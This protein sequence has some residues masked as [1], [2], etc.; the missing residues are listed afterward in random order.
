MSYNGRESGSING[1]EPP[2]GQYVE[3]AD[4][5]IFKENGVIKA[6]NGEDGSIEFSGSDF[7]TVLQNAIDDLYGTPGYGKIY[8]RAGKYTVSSTITLKGSIRLV[9]AGKNRTNLTLAD[10][11]N[12]DLIHVCPDNFA[13][14]P[15]I[16]FMNISGN[17]DNNTS[18]NG[19]VNYRGDELQL[20]QVHVGNC[21]GNAVRMM[22]RGTETVGHMIMHDMTLYNCD[23][24]NLYVGEDGSNVEGLKIVDNIIG[25]WKSGGIKITD[26]SGAKKI[27]I[28]GN[29]FWG[30]NNDILINGGSQINIVGNLFHSVAGIYAI[31][32]GGH[33]ST[34][35]YNALVTGN[36]IYGTGDAPDNA[37]VIG[38]Y[39][40]R[41]WVRNNRIA[42][43]SSQYSL[44]SNTLAEGRTPIKKV[45]IKPLDTDGAMAQIGQHTAAVLHDGATESAWFE[46]RA[47]ID[48]RGTKDLQGI[49]VSPATGD[50]YRKILVD[51][52]KVGE[53]YNTHEDSHG[54]ITRTIGTADQITKE[55]NLNALVSPLEQGDYLGVQFTRWD[56]GTNDTLGGDL[57]VLGMVLKYEAT[58]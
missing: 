45:F 24:P 6:K 47:P 54:F 8:I 3:T 48:L 38:D 51:I 41:V 31:K 9:G 17:R 53:A 33:A 14:L 42:N 13:I 35:N 21:V 52:G 29:E 1:R 50:Y 55:G 15:E 49:V 58:L 32:F 36:L 22:P 26:G 2:L 30:G 25:C 40:N 23:S 11:A 57:Y 46:C 56:D 39:G 43:C 28:N 27:L 20:Y 5:V 12:T 44:G 18:G 10:G 34:F 7:A 37:V 4:Y 19:I 16:G